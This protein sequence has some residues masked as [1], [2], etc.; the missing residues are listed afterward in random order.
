VGEFVVVAI[1]VA[2]FLL[3]ALWAA[4]VWIWDF[5]TDL[6]R[7]ISGRERRDREEQE[8]QSL[9]IERVQ[10]QFRAAISNGGYPTED[11]ISFVLS[12]DAGWTIPESLWKRL[13]NRATYREAA[14]RIRK[15]QHVS[16]ERES[17]KAEFKELANRFSEI[18]KMGETPWSEI[19]RVAQ[20]VHGEF[21][22]IPFLLV[23]KS[24]ILGILKSMAVANGCVP[25][26]LGRIYQA[27]RAAIEPDEYLTVDETFNEIAHMG[28]R[29]V[30]LPVAVQYL[31][32][33]DR[34]RPILAPIVAEG[35]AAL[36]EAAFGCFPNSMPVNH[37]KDT[38]LE[39][40]RPYI[41]EGRPRGSESSSGNRSG[42]E[43]TAQSTGNCLKCPEY[44][45]VLRLKPDANEEEIRTRYRDLAQIYHP[46]KFGPGKERLKQTA[47]DEMK[48][49][50]EAYGHIEKHFECAKV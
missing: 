28:H 7:R 30:A 31:H 49:V 16:G 32:A 26:S 15:E 46:D 45:A 34:G 12:H 4:I 21:D 25:V 37:V 23:L 47:E 38:Y 40:L 3:Y 18:L 20:A 42:N 39:L 22:S 2:L 36:I 50:N 17:A 9:E 13:G 24:D 1:I 8:R 10:E 29:K 11:T 43:R 41:S 44:Y 33:Y 35:Y 48:K 14:I 19:T 27:V 5:L 6:F